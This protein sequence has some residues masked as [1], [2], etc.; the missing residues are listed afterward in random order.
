MTARSGASED[1]RNVPPGPGDTDSARGQ[2]GEVSRRSLLRSGLA[3][4]GTVGIAAVMGRSAT[5]AGAAPPP[6]TALRGGRP[7]DLG[8]RLELMAG[9]DVIDRLHGSRLLLHPP[10][11]RGVA[12]TTDEPWEGC[13]SHFRTVFKDGSIFRMY[14][15]GYHYITAGGKVTIPHPEYQCYAESADGIVWTRPTLNLVEHEGSNSN[16][17]ILYPGSFSAMGITLAPESFGVFRDDSPNATSD[18]RYKGVVEGRSSDGYG[19]YALESG[20]GIH[21]RL[22]S[23]ERILTQGQQGISTSS[24]DSLNLAFWDATRDQY[25]LYMRDYNQGTQSSFRDIKTSTSSDFLHW[26]DPVWLSYPNSPETELYTNNVAPYYRAPHIFV[27]TPMRY[28]GHGATWTVSDD[29]LPGLAD[30]KARFEASPRY[31]TAITDALFMTSR[32]GL[33]FDR[34]DE[35]YIRPGPG[36]D[37]WVYGDNSPAWGMLE[38]SSAVPGAPNE[39]SMYATAGYWQGDSLDVVRY[40]SRIDGFVSV[41]FPPDGGEFT[42]RS[43]LVSG[44]KL[45]INFDTSAP[46][47]LKV[48]VQSPGGRP[49]GGFDLAGSDALFGD[50]LGRAVSWRGGDSDL[51]RLRGRPVRLRFVGRDADLYSIRFT[52]GSED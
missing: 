35:S 26:R 40:A 30:R 36:A 5:S 9:T 49:I 34:F 23:T 41:N 10:Q 46:G 51:S 1:S 27:A 42:T 32:D 14:Y 18:S 33:T 29:Y 48:E 8:S 45:V 7:I 37:N 47:D 31:G 22:M 20:D 52:D 24:F 39:L 13:S 25:R 19:L 44:R 4:G 3:V 15:L 28:D 2:R 6:V 11:R 17:I 12:M 21:W 16:N 43:I 38:T 50:D